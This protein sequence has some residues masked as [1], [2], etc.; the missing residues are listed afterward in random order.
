ML[1]CDELTLIQTENL[2]LECI[3]IPKDDSRTYLGQ[4]TKVFEDI[5]CYKE[6]RTEVFEDIKCMIQGRNI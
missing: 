5:K 3:I 6:E 2:L 4:R 1:H